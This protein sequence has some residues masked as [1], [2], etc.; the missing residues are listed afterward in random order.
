MMMSISSRVVKNTIYLYIKSIV[1]MIV[2]L[3]VTRIVLRSLGVIDYGIY[4]VVAGS[5]AILG[6]FRNSLAVT[7]QR[8][9]N[10]YQGE[11][12]FERQEQVFNIGIV[13]HWTVAIILVLFFFILGV[14]LFNGILNI[15]EER[16]DAAKLVY[17][18]LIV[19]TVV[20]VVTAPY[21]AT[22]T[23]HENMLFYSIVGVADTFFKLAIAFVIEYAV[24]DKLIIYAILMM[25]IP[26]I[27]TIV[28][29]LYCKRNYAECSF[30]PK[31]N[32]DG[33]LAKD[34]MQ[35]AGWSLVG[36]STNVV[37]NHGANLALNHFFGAA[38][39]AVTGIANQI[40]GV[41]AV[42][43]NGLLKSLTPV[44]FKTEGA[45]NISNMLKISILGCKYSTLLFS[46]LA[47][48]VFI[49]T[50]LLLRLWLVEVPDWTILFVRLQLIR[51]FVEQL[52]ASM[53]ESVHATGEVRKLNIITG[54]FNILPVIVLVVLY[55]LGFPPY[56]HYIVMILLMT[57]GQNITVLLLCRNY[58]SL[59]IRDFI[60][61]VVI[62]CLVITALASIFSIP[63][64]LISNEL[65]GLVLCV[66]ISSG[67][68]VVLTYF[69]MSIEERSLIH[70]MIK[71]VVMRIKR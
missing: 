54:F 1:T 23:A 53:L 19:N 68:F 37:S 9:L 4:N 18:C 43:L 2:M 48:P 27:E 49:Y 20:T 51:A 52:G 36:A 11:D 39:N 15:P 57:M 8:Y 7:M 50:P 6:F 71:N 32:W 28:M 31:R 10:H 62:P 47:V 69:S 29:R 12:N 33:F 58:C 26:F 25:I 46:F 45:G 60:T 42:L 65:L 34:M 64:L 44:I 30:H 16:M 13:F 38:I 17:L 63:S 5:I 56:W 55:S 41:L 40:Q 24:G 3:F 21:D 67:S 22:I 61:S 14:F 66:I 59:R 70:L 35:F